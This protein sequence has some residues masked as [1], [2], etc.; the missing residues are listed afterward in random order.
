M[1]R[2]IKVAIL[3]VFLLLNSCGLYNHF[4]IA[5][6][7]DGSYTVAPTF[8]QDFSFEIINNRI[9]IPV[10]IQGREYNFLFDTGSSLV[11][12]SELL[13]Q[14]E[15][16]NV[17]R[18]KATDSNE[19]G[20]SLQ[21]VKLAEIESFGTLFKAQ[22]AIVMD[23]NESVRNSCINISGIFGASVMKDL[24]WQINFDKQTI[25]VSDQIENMEVD[26]YHFQ[27]P[28]GK[29]PSETPVIDVHIDGKKEKLIIDTGS[30]STFSF[31]L[32]S[33]TSMSEENIFT[34][35][36]T[37][38]GVFGVSYDTILHVT[39][40][41]KLDPSTSESW[42]GVVEFRK[43]LKKGV[44]GLGFLKDYLITIDWINQYLYLN[45]INHKPSTFSTYGFSIG[46]AGE[47]MILSH[48]FENSRAQEE[49]LMV[50]DTIKE[51]DGLNFVNSSEETL[52]NFIGNDYL[53]SID[54]PVLLKVNDMKDYIQLTK[55]FLEE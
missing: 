17:A 40:V 50:G 51:I 42:R 22:G 28:F 46:K 15:Y 21:Y 3:P 6:V 18:I 30:G 48:V 25:K 14:L 8:N 55:V 45:R 20:R 36:G 54:T 23:L 11:L 53:K 24:I 47:Y 16:E 4:K 37:F 52:C 38:G 26:N 31:P 29:N 34:A 27:L 32:K 13:N 35:V 41:I 44:V 1:H 33:M 12:N 49:G 43:S 2:T 39:K 7:K 5:K 9:V 10:I 19:K